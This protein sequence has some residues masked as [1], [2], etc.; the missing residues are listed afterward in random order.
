MWSN[1]WDSVRINYEFIFTMDDTPVD[2]NIVL[3]E[4]DVTFFAAR[5]ETRR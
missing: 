5:V 4:C 2:R 3:V 1:W